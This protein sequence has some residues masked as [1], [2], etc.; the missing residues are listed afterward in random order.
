MFA[1]DGLNP[2]PKGRISNVSAVPSYQKIHPVDRGRRNVKCVGRGPFGQ[3]H[4]PEQFH[5]KQF[6][7]FGLAHQRYSAQHSQPRGRRSR[8]AC[9]ALTN[10]KFRHV[11]VVIALT[12]PPLA[13]NLLVG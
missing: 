9:L 13:R 5:C 1:A 10:D 4:V 7:R 12:V 2:A 6:D 11:Q 3:R 8:V